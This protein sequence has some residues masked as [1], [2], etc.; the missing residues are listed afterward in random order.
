M[1]RTAANSIAC[2][3]WRSQ[4]S[5]R[6]GFGPARQ[7]ESAWQ[8]KAVMLPE[9]RSL[10]QRTSDPEIRLAAA[11]SQEITLLRLPH[12]PPEQGALRDLLCVTPGR[13]TL[14]VQPPPRQTRANPQVSTTKSRETAHHDREL[15]PGGQ[16]GWCSCQPGEPPGFGPGGMMN[17]LVTDLV[18]AGE[19][20]HLQRIRGQARRAAGQR[21]AGRRSCGRTDH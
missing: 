14:R 7:G 15:N 6:N 13:R 1:L 8:A 5:S 2:A 16:V 21:P 12:N 19:D 11:K 18:F 9:L 17:K 10:R 4:A 3:C 20:R